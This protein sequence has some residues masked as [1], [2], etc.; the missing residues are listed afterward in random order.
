MESSLHVAADSHG[1]DTPGPAPRDPSDSV[2]PRPGDSP[3]PSGDTPTALL[4][5]EA[6]RLVGAETSAVT[7]REL[8]SPRRL[9][10]VCHRASEDLLALANRDP[11]AGG[12]WQYV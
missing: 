9:E 6:I 1:T 11:A 10:L 3:A 8:L 4:R 5:T 2:F 12:S 7:A